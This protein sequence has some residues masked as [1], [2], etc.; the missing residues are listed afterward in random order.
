MG[1]NVHYAPYIEF[2]TKL[3][4]ADSYLGWAAIKNGKL[5]VDRIMQ[6][7]NKIKT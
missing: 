3:I 7:L 6:E 1:T 2:G 4:R 5:I